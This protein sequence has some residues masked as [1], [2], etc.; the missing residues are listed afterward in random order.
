MSTKRKKS[1]ERVAGSASTT[2][3]VNVVKALKVQMEAR[4]KLYFRHKGVVTD[5]REVP[6]HATQLRAAEA[7]CKIMGLC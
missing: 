6:D 5:V 1:P 3:V 7:L 2:E 4:K